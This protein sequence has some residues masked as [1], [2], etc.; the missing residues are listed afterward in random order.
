MKILAIETSCDDSCVAL[1]NIKR[2]RLKILSDFVSS[3]TKIHAPYGGVVPN[4]AVR[5]HYKNLPILLESVLSKTDVK[6]ID[7]VAVTTGPGLEP[8]LWAGTNTARILAMAMG[9]PIIGVNHLEGHVAANFFSA[10]IARIRRQAE[11]KQSRGK[12][13]GSPRSIYP[14]RSR[15]ARDDEE[16]IFPAICLIVSGG[17]TQL[18]LIKK[19]GDYKVIGQTRDDAAGEAFDKVAKLLG[20][21]YPGGPVIALKAKKGRSDAFKLPRP[22]IDS[23]DFDF[24]FSGLKTAVLYLLTP[25][26]PFLSKGG[27]KGGVVKKLLPQTVNDLCASFQQAVIDVLIQK[28]IRAAK[29][30]RAKTVMLSGGVAANKELRRQIEKIIKIQIPRTQFLVPDTQY[31]TDNA[32]MIGMA[33]YWKY[34]RSGGDKMEKI[35]AKANLCL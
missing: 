33:G 7:L 9:K 13:A 4:L 28:T 18:V 5:A 24:S 22:M 2:G 30:Y 20:L 26:H 19:I 23:S 21:G 34:K 25:P 15:R 31:C 27:R 16:G 1:L 12:T 17:H 29:D 3:Q 35:V 10:V 14:E 8:S 11:T 32:V 6:K